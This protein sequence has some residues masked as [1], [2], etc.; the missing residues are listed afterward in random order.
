MTNHQASLEALLVHERWARALARDMVRD[1]DR[2]DEIVQR[3][4]LAALRWPPAPEA[5]LQAW[6]ATVIRN[7]VR[8]D[9]RSNANRRA[10][11]ER[12]ARP[13]DDVEG[14]DAALQVRDASDKLRAAVEALREP[15]RTRITERYFE[16]LKP[17]EIA[18]RSGLA[19]DT[20]RTQLARG[21]AEL[22]TRMARGAGEGRDAWILSVAPLLAVRRRWLPSAAAARAAMWTIFALVPATCLYL[23]FGR[24]LTE[25]AGDLAATL[26]G[27][28]IVDAAAISP[29]APAG[30]ERTPVAHLARALE[31]ICVDG[32][33]LRPLE[34][35]L[36][37]A[38]AL[39]DD[40]A[41]RES[42]V[43][44]LRS[45]ALTGTGFDQVT[46]LQT[47][48]NGR[49][50]VETTGG[51]QLVTASYESLWDW[52]EVGPEQGSPVHLALREDD[53][54]QVLVID[55]LGAPLEGVLVHFRGFDYCWDVEFSDSPVAL[56]G[57]DGIAEL[58]HVGHW[59]WSSDSLC[60]PVACIE[61][62]VIGSQSRWISVD[63]ENL[64]ENPVEVR[65]SGELGLVEV[66]IV[67][68]DGSPIIGNGRVH[69]DWIPEGE[70][71]AL[72]AFSA[73][74]I[75]GALAFHMPIGGRCDIEVESALRGIY[76]A[77]IEG[78]RVIGEVV[79]L[80]LGEEAG[81]S[82][83]TGQLV[84][85][86]GLPM[87]YTEFEYSPPNSVARGVTDASGRFRVRIVDALLD[88]LAASVFLG[89]RALPVGVRS[90]AMARV[91]V[92]LV[93]GVRDLGPIQLLAEEASV[94]GFVS[95]SAG[96][97]IAGASLSVQIRDQE[98][99]WGEK[100]ATMTDSDGR[101]A[102]GRNGDDWGGGER[103]VVRR[104]GYATGEVDFDWGQSDVS[105]VLEP[106]RVVRG[107]VLVDPTMASESI[108]IAL[109]SAD[110]RPD[111]WRPRESASDR[112]S[113]FGVEVERLRGDGRFTFRRMSDGPYRLQ[114]IR[115]GGDELDVVHE[116][117]PLTL[118]VEGDRYG[119]L[120]DIDLRGAFREVEI[121]VVDEAGMPISDA[122][123]YV[124]GL[125]VGE[126]TSS[127]DGVS[128]SYATDLDGSAQVFASLEGSIVEISASGYVDRSVEIELDDVVV[129][130]RSNPPREYLVNLDPLEVPNGLVLSLGSESRSELGS[131]STH[132]CWKHG[133]EF[134][135]RG[136]LCCP[137]SL[138]GPVEHW[139]TL[140]DGLNRV[141][142]DEPRQLEAL[143]ANRTGRIY[144][145]AP[146]AG[147][148]SCAVDELHRLAEGEQ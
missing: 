1:I 17:G 101:F 5:K 49:C 56:T 46:E 116:A 83:F 81:D 144:L 42:A 37:R 125:L 148:L 3:A 117:G 115:G 82:V 8:S 9:A 65:V 74:L 72:S 140:S 124:E 53:N 130:L 28:S 95:D 58:A 38:W 84:D 112:F 33:T 31:A 27:P 63:R 114:V 32:L 69:V 98:E 96:Q 110:L 103:L 25:P 136:V 12:H 80:D 54:V 4:Y 88:D 24:P 16:E 86:V 66:R 108:F 35:A 70:K 99:W 118:A 90:S 13:E 36:I 105:I 75:E 21:L 47:D 20:V 30:A 55:D 62:C 91:E 106:E 93:P 119:V 57:P 100:A 76:H 50:K 129:V 52:A 79:R 126:R 111:E 64:P 18:R 78:P 142:V 138:T 134:D 145:A 139:F 73:P 109:M 104:D 67:D 60:K 120:D 40:P 51:Y 11:E 29:A 61:A 121:L 6:L 135:E 15:Y 48:G 7:I 146:D 14:A 113:N 10:R 68:P 128:E 26:V 94:T 59:L 23:F 137:E 122:W 127:Y 22:R 97:P 43:R 85:E 34:G 89:L 39:P 133:G 147:S 131:I 77:T 123:V 107:R 71:D 143:D 19:I 41:L 141:T 102:L 45:G 44:R 92:S 132:D 2:A 87:T